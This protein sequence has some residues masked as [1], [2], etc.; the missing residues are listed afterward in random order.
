[1]PHIPKK[2]HSSGEIDPEDDNEQLLNLKEVR[3]LRRIHSIKRFEEDQ[4]I[5]DV[6]TENQEKKSDIPLVGNEETLD[7]VKKAQSDEE[8]SH[9]IYKYI[10][11]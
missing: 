3:D 7:I 10:L 1:M 9:E 11:N 2:S 6:Q 4:N 8:V 5:N